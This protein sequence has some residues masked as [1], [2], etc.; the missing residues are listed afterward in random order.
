MKLTRLSVLLIVL[1]SV[2]FICSTASAALMQ[3]TVHKVTAPTY[4]GD[5]LVL[6]S[7]VSTPSNS[8]YIVLL[9][10]HPGANKAVAT[11]LTALSM[12][13]NIEINVTNTNLST[14]APEVCWSLGVLAP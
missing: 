14:T 5:V 4:N 11:V 13:Q 1:V 6:V 8:G 7:Q 2:F 9:H 10:S 3:C 12:G